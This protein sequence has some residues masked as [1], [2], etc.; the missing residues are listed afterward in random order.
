MILRTVKRLNRKIAISMFTLLEV[1]RLPR[2]NEKHED[3]G[4]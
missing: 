4:A 2:A 3:R 1:L